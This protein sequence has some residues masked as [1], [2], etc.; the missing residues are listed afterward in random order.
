MIYVTHDQVE[1]MTL[2]DRIVV[3][4][5]G[6]IQQVDT[7]GALY[8]R[9]RNTFVASFIGTPPMNLIEGRVSDGRFEAE[10]FVGWQTGGWPVSTGAPNGQQIVLGVRPEDLQPAPGWADSATSIAARVELVELLG[11]E[12]LVHVRAGNSEL[13]ARIPSPVPTTGSDIRLV[14]PPDKVHLFAADSGARLKRDESGQ[15]RSPVARSS[16]PRPVK[17][18]A[19][20]KASLDSISHARGEAIR[21]H[22]TMGRRTAAART[23]G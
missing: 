7:P 14:V 20:L 2:G 21:P 16:A 13:T 5:E 4:H 3:L 22:G 11:G 23:R 6:A 10:G 15:S 9:P 17:W 8:E 18:M 1:A 12:A 19:R